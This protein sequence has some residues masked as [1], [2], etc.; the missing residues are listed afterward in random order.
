MLL[1]EKLSLINYFYH[2]MET[3]MAFR[4]SYDPWVTQWAGNVGY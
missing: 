4:L 3:L 1:F 2:L